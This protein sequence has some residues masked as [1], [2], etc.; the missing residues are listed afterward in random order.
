MAFIIV[1]VCV[2]VDPHAGAPRCPTRT[3]PH[4]AEQGV[5]KHRAPKL[6]TTTVA[7]PRDDSPGCSQVPCGLLVAQIHAP[8]IRDRKEFKNS[9]KESR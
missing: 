2:E 1:G 5:F 9:R 3:G 7:L 8:P 4:Q 6:R